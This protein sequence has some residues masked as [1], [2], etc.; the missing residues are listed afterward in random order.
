MSFR[1]NSKTMPNEIVKNFR[2]STTIVKTRRPATIDSMSYPQ[3]DLD[4]ETEV[5]Y[6]GSVRRLDGRLILNLQW[7]D[8]D[9]NGHRV[10]LPHEVVTAIISAYERVMKTARSERAQKAYQTKLSNGF[11]PFIKS[12]EEED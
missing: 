2:A 3:W 9:S 6:L 11:V 4:L 8:L 10:E 1:S 5:H 7:V 12:T